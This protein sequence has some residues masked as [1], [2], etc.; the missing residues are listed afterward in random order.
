MT[1]V[2]GVLTHS[3]LES[4]AQAEAILEVASRRVNQKREKGT[5]RKGGLR[6]VI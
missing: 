3:N 5:G 2:I 1:G 4:A 6:F